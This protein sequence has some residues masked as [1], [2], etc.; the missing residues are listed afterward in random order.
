M[1]KNQKILLTIF[2]A[3]FIV[4]EVLWNTVS[5]PIYTFFTPIG[6]DGVRVLRD[7][8]LFQNRWIGLRNAIIVIQTIGMLAATILWFRLRNMNSSKYY[9]VILMLLTVILIVSLMAFSLAVDYNP[10]PVI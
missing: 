2:L 5:N 7:N 8:I 9:W 3:M 4:P 1:T 10:S 6:P